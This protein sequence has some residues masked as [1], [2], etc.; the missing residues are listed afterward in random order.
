MAEMI[1]PGTYIE[2]RAEGLIAPGPIS[3]GNV[4]IV[5][6]ARRGKI[7]NTA[8]PTTVYTPSNLGEAREIFGQYDAYDNPEE[9]NHELTLIRALELAYANGASRVFVA[10]VADESAA[11]AAYT[12]PAGD[13]TNVTITAVAPG[14]GYNGATLTTGAYAPNIGMRVADGNI[15][16]ES[17]GNLPTDPADFIDRINDDSLRFTAANNGGDDDIAIGAAVARTTDGVDPTAAVF[18]V[19]AG[20]GTIAFTARQPGIAMNSASITIADGSDPA[21]NCNV[22]LN[23][24]AGTVESHEDVPRIFANFIAALAGS[25]LFIVADVDADADVGNQNVAVPGT[26]GTAGTAA[27][28][29]ITAGSG[30]VDLTARNPGIAANDWDISIHG[31]F[32]VTFTLAASVETWREAPTYPTGFAQVIN[33]NHPTY[34]FSSLAS[35]GGG[36]SLFTAAAGVATGNLQAGQ[37]TTQTGNGT[38]GA[39]AGPD[40]YGRGLAALENEDVHIVVL[41]GQD[42][43]DLL[44]THVENASGDLMKRERIGVIG[45][46]P[47]G[48]RTDLVA[49]SQDSGRI[50][51]VG[52]GCKSI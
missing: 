48:R 39:N 18:S 19:T 17:L 37:E 40:D 20:T 10:R 36:S 50:V 31:Y 38:N 6:T 5:G 11:S 1:L 23:D 43:S 21:N 47:S 44:I 52:S 22:T 26:A 12:F 24:G 16:I 25:A 3:I 35:N 27:V 49:A 15:A 2:V 34:N 4:G 28:F 7:A 42:T 51:F 14:N 13:G 41:A 8:D 30:T 45:S 46:D 33:G 32:D 9:P 29:E